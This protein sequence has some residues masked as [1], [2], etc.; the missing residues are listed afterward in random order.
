M[1][2]AASDLGL[3]QRGLA[4]PIDAVDG[5]NVLGEIDADEYDGHVTCPFR[6]S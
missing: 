6:M 2:L 1:E 4:V 5:E 3:H